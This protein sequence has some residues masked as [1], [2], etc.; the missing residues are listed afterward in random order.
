MHLTN[1][2]IY[3]EDYDRPDGVIEILKPINDVKQNESLN[4]NPILDKYEEVSLF[5]TWKS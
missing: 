3:I 1:C 5:L 4:K 2:L